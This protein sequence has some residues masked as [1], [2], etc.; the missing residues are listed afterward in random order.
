[1]IS[2]FAIFFSLGN[3]KSVVTKLYRIIKEVGEGFGVLEET[4]R[5]ESPG[6]F[7]AFNGPQTFICHA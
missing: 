1:V 7:M 4:R 6:K 5:S 3:I 2:F